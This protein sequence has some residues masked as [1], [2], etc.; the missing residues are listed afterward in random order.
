MATILNSELLTAEEYGHLPDDGRL[1]ELVRGRIVEMNRPFTSHSYYLN[2]IGYLLTQFVEQHEL[3]RMVS[4]D[5]GVVTERDPDSVRGPDVAYYSYQ[6]IPCGPLPDEYWPTSPELIIEVRSKNDRWKVVLKKVAEVFD[7]G[8]EH[9]CGGRPC[10]TAGTYLFR[11]RR[12]NRL[13]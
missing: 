13:E 7:G 4:G 12:D 1:T 8:C 5:V 2:R 9:G 11:R 3:G 10:S 6:R